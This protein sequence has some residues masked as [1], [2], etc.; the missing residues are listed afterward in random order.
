MHNTHTHTHKHIHTHT[1][2]HTHTHLPPSASRMQV[3]KV[4]GYPSFTPNSELEAGTPSTISKH[5]GNSKTPSAVVVTVTLTDVM[6][7]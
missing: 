2:T 6:F 1:H 4:D 7:G 5:S 3:V